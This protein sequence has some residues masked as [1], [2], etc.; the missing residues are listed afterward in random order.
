[1]SQKVGSLKSNPRAGCPDVI[2]SG[3]MESSRWPAISSLILANRGSPIVL[4]SDPLIDS[5]SFASIILYILSDKINSYPFVFF[6]PFVVKS[7]R[8]HIRWRRP[9]SAR[10]GVKSPAINF[11]VCIVTLSQ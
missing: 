10:P 2:T 7:F 5:P 6:V 4:L 9:G 1:M 3:L 11:W 8:R